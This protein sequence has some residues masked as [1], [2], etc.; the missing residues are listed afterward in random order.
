MYWIEN[1]Y[2]WDCRITSRW[3]ERMERVDLDGV[4]QGQEFFSL[5]SLI[6]VVRS[7]EVSFYWNYDALSF[8]LSLSSI[9]LVYTRPYVHFSTGFA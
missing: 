8:L 1:L 2:P 3:P 4:K 9:A 7:E 5:L 6:V